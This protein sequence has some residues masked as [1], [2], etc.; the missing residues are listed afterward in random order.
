MMRIPAVIR[1][2]KH[3]PV[4][5]F[6]QDLHDTS[7]FPPVKMAL[8]KGINRYSPFMEVSMAT[9]ILFHSVYGLRQGVLDAAAFLRNH[10]HSVITPDLY[11]GRVFDD[12]G[13]AQRFME[14]IG[15]RGM[16]ERTMTAAADLPSDVVYAG[17]SN[18]GAS[19]GLLAGT[20]PGA[21]GCL[22]FHA[23]LPLQMLGIP[24]WPRTVPVQVHYARSDPWRNQQ[25]VDQFAAD[26]RASGAAYEF[27]EYPVAGHLFTDPGL[28]EYDPA[29]AMLLHERALS[30]VQRV[31]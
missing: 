22:L 25:W 3:D 29:S 7:C 20:R 14:E 31:G 17:F 30:F 15:I 12:I 9:V 5:I 24:A 27:F 16:I 26:I 1:I 28:P 6:R 11:H 18:G 21:R 8:S 23:A 19:A 10:G 2:P 4:Q 13:K